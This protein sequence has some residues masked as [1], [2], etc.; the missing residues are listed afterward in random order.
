MSV[1]ALSLEQAHFDDPTVR[2]L[3]E[4]TVAELN[5]HYDGRPGSGAKPLASEFEAPDGTFLLAM[6][7]GAPIGCDGLCRFDDETCEIRRMYVAPQARRQ[8]ISRAILAGLLDAGRK[9]GYKRARLETGFAQ[10]EAIGL[11]ETSGFERIPCWGP[12]ITDERSL[13]FERDL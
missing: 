7:D 13:C 12:Y 4:A 9:L 2:Q 10:R 3:T 1:M 8:G 11:Y 5:S 6:L